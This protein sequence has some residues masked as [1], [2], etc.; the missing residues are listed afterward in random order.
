MPEHALVSSAS[1][2][3][4]AFVRPSAPIEPVFPPSPTVTTSLEAV[5]ADVRSI[6]TDVISAAGLPAFTLEAVTAPDRPRLTHAKTTAR[7]E[8]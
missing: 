1:S 6:V 7:S 2:T 8:S 3:V 5:S 4:L